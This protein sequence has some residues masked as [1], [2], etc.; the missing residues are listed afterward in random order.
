[1]AEKL[2]DADALDALWAA[3]EALGDYRGETAKGDTALCAARTA[4]G[5]L[6]I[7][8]AG[9]EECDE[10]ELRGVIEPTHAPSTQH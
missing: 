5:M 8:M 2:S 6:V 10:D 9:A 3:L 4:L 7:S 1:M